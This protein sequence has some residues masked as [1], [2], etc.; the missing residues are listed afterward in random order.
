MAT[1]EI[2]VNVISDHSS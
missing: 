2:D 1:K